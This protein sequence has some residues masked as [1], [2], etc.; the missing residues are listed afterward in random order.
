MRKGG[1]LL[2]Q[3][4]RRNKRGVTVFLEFS[5]LEKLKIL[6]CKNVD[7]YIDLDT[8]TNGKYLES[9]SKLHINRDI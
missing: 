2:K 9:Y 4:E 3:K 1:D 5:L 7:F 6:F 8:D